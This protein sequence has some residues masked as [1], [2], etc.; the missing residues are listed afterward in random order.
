MQIKVLNLILHGFNEPVWWPYRY[1][2]IIC[3]FMITLVLRCYQQREGITA[4]SVCFSTA[5]ITCLL[6]YVGR[7]HFSWLTKEA[8]FLNIILLFCIYV[9]WGIAAIPESKVYPLIL[10]LTG[11]D[12]MMNGWMIL[13]D[14]TAYQRSETVSNFRQ[15]FDDSLPAIEA[16]TEH[17]DGFY[18]TE[19]TYFRDANDAMTLGYHGVSHYS[20]TLNYSLMQFLPK[21]GYRYYPWRFLY[22]EGSDL[23]ADSLLGIRYL[24]SDEGSIDKSYSEAMSVNGKTIF[25]NPFSLPIAF[26]GKDNQL[27]DRNAITFELQNEIF[28]ALTGGQEN[29]YSEAVTLSSETENLRAAV[30]IPGCYERIDQDGPAMI[31]WTVNNTAGE[32]LYL[33]LRNDS[34]NQLPANI[35]V[36]NEF[37]AEYFDG[38]GIPILPVRADSGLTHLTISLEPRND[39]ICFDE[40]QAY[41]ENPEVLGKYASDLQKG[42]VRLER[43]SSA[44]VSGEISAEEDGWLIISIP[45]DPGW[46]MW[47]DGKR[48]EPEKAFEIFLSAPVSEGSHEFLI[49]YLPE[50]LEI[51]AAVTSGTILLLILNGIRRKRTK[52]RHDPKQSCL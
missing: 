12:L 33:Y 35:F 24:I 15:F 8:L 37:Q 45:Y 51:G 26:F 36:N 38:K 3:L 21:M 22:G 2:F 50:G 48:T 46:R 17:D 16:L 52:A 47:I 44:A 39:M 13:E 7:Q 30:N 31:R 23:A 27:A 43:D 29:I 25:R 1:S 32:P 41:S 19:K 9:L 11:I 10:I 6:L 42:T 18:R 49:K 28:R 4:L 40:M 5:V 14:K 34:D 20:S